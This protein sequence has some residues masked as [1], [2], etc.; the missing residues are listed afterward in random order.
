MNYNIR[1]AKE[2]DFEA[3]L[4]LIK[5]L[6]LFENAP[7]KVLN[8]VEQMKA[9]QDFFHCFVVETE[10]QEIVGMAL[11]Y[12]VYYTWVGKSMYLDDLYVKQAFR[13]QG[14]GSELLEK[15]FEV[16]RKENCKRV[17][18]QV[19]DW[20]EPAIALYEKCGAEIDKE[21]YNCDFDQQGIQSFSIK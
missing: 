8:T 5:E 21:W 15:L 4:G 2:E 18:W 9:E 6:A 12:F 13:G 19:L 11:Y 14:I 16:A 3:I 17:R 20:N 7:E 1:T 10:A